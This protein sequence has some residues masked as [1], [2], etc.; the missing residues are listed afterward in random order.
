MN[1]SDQPVPRQEAMAQS[2]QERQWMNIFNPCRKKTH[3]HFG[4]NFHLQPPDTFLLSIADNLDHFHRWFWLEVLKKNSKKINKKWDKLPKPVLNI[5][6]LESVKTN[7]CL[8]VDVQMFWE[9]SPNHHTRSN[10]RSTV[11]WMRCWAWR[12]KGLNRHHRRRRKLWLRGSSP[13]IS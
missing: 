3:R 12:N 6:L 9:I 2:Y 4:I 7:M 11:C 10:T 5:T 13:I 8:F 1:N